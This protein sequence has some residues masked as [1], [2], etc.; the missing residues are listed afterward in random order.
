MLA[1]K[2]AVLSI[3]T[4]CFVLTIFLVKKFVVKNKIIIQF[5]NCT[6]QDISLEPKY[7]MILLL[8]KEILNT[9]F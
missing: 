9:K 3:I 2:A 8:A 1:E 4:T 5:A 7:L 6:K